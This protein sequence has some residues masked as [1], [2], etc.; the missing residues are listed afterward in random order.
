M[1]FRFGVWGFGGLGFRS[2]CIRLLP[3]VRLKVFNWVPQTKLSFLSG[4]PDG[5]FLRALRGPVLGSNWVL[6][7]FGGLP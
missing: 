1:G 3:K 2:F 5:L 6:A 7:V 4:L